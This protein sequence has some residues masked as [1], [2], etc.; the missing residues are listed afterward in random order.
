VR[1]YIYH[2]HLFKVNRFLHCTYWDLEGVA[3][4]TAGAK[5]FGKRSDAKRVPFVQIV[6]HLVPF[7]TMMAM[8][9]YPLLIF[10][11]RTVDRFEKD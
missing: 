6:M 2:A 7:Q 4:A 11:A 3:E 9:I 8:F 10:F 1:C 5:A